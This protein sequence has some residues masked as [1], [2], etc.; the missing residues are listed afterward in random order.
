MKSEHDWR[1]LQKLRHLIAE[2]DNPRL[3]ETS[4]RIEPPKR[5][6]AAVPPTFD[7]TPLDVLLASVP[8]LPRAILAA[9]MI[10]RLDKLD[11]DTD[12]E[13]G[14]DSRSAHRPAEPLRLLRRTLRYNRP[15]INRYHY[16]GSSEV[17]PAEDALKLFEYLHGQLQK[18][19]ARMRSASKLT[20]ATPRILL[21]RKAVSGF[22]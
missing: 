16:V 6:P 9:R 12:L 5:L 10:E 3:I 22:R 2:I 15:P 7:T 11:G 21:G 4:Q 1:L 13:V 20:A 8:S 18:R 17:A 14:A 19:F